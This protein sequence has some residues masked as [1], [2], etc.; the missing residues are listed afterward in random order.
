MLHSNISDAY[1]T[2]KANALSQ[3][4]IEVLASYNNDVKPNY[5]KQ[6]VATV[7]GDTFLNNPILHHEVFGPFSLVVQCKNV[8]QLES[9]ITN[10]E[11]QL[12]GTII[13]D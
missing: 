9:I 5:A 2:N 4:G 11:G 13:S 1:N 7:E 10:L 3:S 6:L 12:T 8:E